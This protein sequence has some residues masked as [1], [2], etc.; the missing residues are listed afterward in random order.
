MSYQAFHVEINAGIA[1]VIMNRPDSFNAMD[2]AFWTEIREIFATLSDNPE[3]RVVVLSS[4]GKHY[5]AGMDLKFFSGVA[6]MPEADPGRQREQI[7]RLVLQF[8]ES[9]NVIERCRVPV[10]T[11]I[12]GACIGGGVDLACACDMRYC[13][14]DA[15]ITIQEIKIGMTADAG[16]LQRLPHLMPSSLVRELAFT[17]RKLGA[18]EALSCGFVSR[19]FDDQDSLVAGV[20]EIAKEIASRSPLAVAGSK[21][22]LNYTRDH[23][24]ADGLNYI[25]TWNAAM[26]IT[27]DLEEGMRAQAEKR[28]PSYDNLLDKRNIG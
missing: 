18:G 5:T 12:H 3:V 19:V 24:V 28:P 26:V 2:A 25:A 14:K 8:Q 7:R 11:A 6:A 21:E 9:F 27:Q 23:S 22:M 1:H 20:L 15:Y 13:S 16:T 17:G 4:T 10:L